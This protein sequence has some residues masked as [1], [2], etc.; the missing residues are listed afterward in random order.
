[1][2]TRKIVAPENN[3]TKAID[4]C[5][6]C[7][8]LRSWN[9]YFGLSYLPILKKRYRFEKDF[10]HNVLT[11]QKNAW[12]ET[13]ENQLC[14]SHWHIIDLDLDC[15]INTFYPGRLFLP[16]VVRGQLNVTNADEYWR[17]LTNMRVVWTS[18]A[19]QAYKNIHAFPGRS[20][21]PVLIYV[22]GFSFE[23]YW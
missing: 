14:F 6:H 18:L 22:N 7:H 17:I 12:T 10:Q 3:R 21:S 19:L 20:S 15:L 9:W 1:M 5:F 13:Y 4:F 11:L 8:R 2:R 23:V 16:E